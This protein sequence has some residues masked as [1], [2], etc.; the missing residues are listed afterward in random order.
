MPRVGHLW[1]GFLVLVGELGVVVAA[2]EWV[3]LGLW[4]EWFAFEGLAA[5]ANCD[6]SCSLT[7]VGA[8][9]V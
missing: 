2:P 6:C 9:L 7:W 8:M 5:T 1:F 4:V 3:E